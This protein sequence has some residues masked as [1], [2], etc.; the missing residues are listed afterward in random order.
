MREHK[1]RVWDSLHK[2]MSEP[3]TFGENVVFLCTDHGQHEVPQDCLSNHQF[4]I[5]EYTGLKD[6]N[7]VEIFEGDI[8]RCGWYYGDDFGNE[9]GEME[10]SNQVV[11]FTV[12]PQGSGFDL[13]VF[14]MEN[15]EV[16]GNIYED[17]P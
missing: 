10:F 15:A 14:G 16:I 6:K 4:T 9:V 11:E 1:Y 8:I 7:G 13:N 2:D 17:K 12:G 5:L 3:F